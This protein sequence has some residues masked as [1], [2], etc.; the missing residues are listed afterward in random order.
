VPV[1]ERAWAALV[2]AVPV[3]EVAGEAA[4]ITIENT[5]SQEPGIAGLCSFAGADQRA[6]LQIATAWSRCFYFL[7]TDTV[8]DHS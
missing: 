8:S 3:E 1:V 4:A 5:V 7:T 6:L 2:G